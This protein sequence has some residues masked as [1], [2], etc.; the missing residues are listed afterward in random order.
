LKIYIAGKIS[1]DKEYRAKFAI[2]ETQLE[3]RGY[4]IFNPAEQIK[5]EKGA[6]WE[7]YMKVA[8]LNMICCDGVALLSD[9]EDSRGATLESYIASELSIPVC[10][11][12]DWKYIC[13][14]ENEK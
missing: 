1:G 8:L 2:A 14:K 7:A 5:L 4:E 12:V 6:T 9:W 11:L 13:F 10:P 3:Q